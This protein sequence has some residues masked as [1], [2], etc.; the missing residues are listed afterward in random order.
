MEQWLWEFTMGLSVAWI[1][2][3]LFELLVLWWREAKQDFKVEQVGRE[4]LLHNIK[5]WRHKP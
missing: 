4:E 1:A 3:S 2:V 5:G